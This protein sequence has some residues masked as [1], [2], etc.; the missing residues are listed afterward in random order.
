[1]S[2]QTSFPLSDDALPLLRLVLESI[3]FPMNIYRTD[4]LAVAANTAFLQM[5]RTSKDAPSFNLFDDP[6]TAEN[7]F[8]A[9]FERAKVGETVTIPPHQFDPSGAGA[10]GEIIWYTTTIFPFSAPDGNIS[11][12]GAVY[13]DVTAQIRVEDERARLTAELAERVKAFQPFY[14]LAENALDGFVLNRMDQRIFYANQ[15]LKTMTGHSELIGVS[16]ADLLMVG[17]GQL[18]ETRQALF[19]TG[20]WQGEVTY[21]HADGSTFPVQV[22]LLLIRNDAGQPLGVASIVRDLRE[23]RRAEEERA[24]LQEQVIA[25]QQ[26]ALRELSTPLIPLTNTVMV[27]PLVGAIDSARAQQIM[28]VL[29]EGIALHQAEVVLLDISGVRVVDTQVADAL[30]RA[31]R[32]VKLLGAQ[33]ILTGISAEIAQTIVHL[34]AD[35]SQISTQA[36]LQSGLRYALKRYGGDLRLS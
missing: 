9:S 14:A 6:S 23:Q 30:L 36:D 24:A 26:A 17:E 31:A 13:Q 32:A 3:P 5:F 18:K 28:E 11:F 25:S 12:I 7:G 8:R 15:A 1:M 2:M 20:A 22:S 29:L 33:V 19:A 27:M 16:I 35:M 10:V 34:G 21:G 4:R